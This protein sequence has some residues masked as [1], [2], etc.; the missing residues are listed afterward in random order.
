MRNVISALLHL[1]STIIIISSFDIHPLFGTALTVNWL[2]GFLKDESF[3][4]KN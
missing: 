4:S 3:K 1:I 2:I